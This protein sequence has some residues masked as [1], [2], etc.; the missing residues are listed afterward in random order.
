MNSYLVK[1][2]ITSLGVKELKPI[3]LP[4]SSGVLALTPK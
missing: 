2:V 4:M 1:G 3:V